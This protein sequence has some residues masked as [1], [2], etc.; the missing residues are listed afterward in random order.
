MEL[1]SFAFCILFFPVCLVCGI[2]VSR[3]KTPWV[4]GFIVCVGLLALLPLATFAPPF[5]PTLSS[6]SGAYVGD[7]G[8]GT[9]T[10]LLHPNGAF[11]QRFVAAS[12]KV[13]SNRGRWTL[14][15]TSQGSIDFDHLLIAF[16]DSGHSQKPEVT[17]FGGAST[18]LFGDSIC[19]D[20]D[21]DIHISCVARRD[22][23]WPR[24]VSPPGGAHH[25]PVP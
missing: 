11:D 2:V 5:H 21:L 12:G 16:G 23:E 17:N 9:D 14:D 13:Y 3:G 6:L 20:D 19:F 15:K 4:G 8:G 7:Y 18:R 10:L 22:S 24:S 1:I 25:P